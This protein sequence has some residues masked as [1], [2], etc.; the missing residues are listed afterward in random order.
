M[1][2]KTLVKA[3]NIIEAGL[4][5]LPDDAKAEWKASASDMFINEAIDAANTALEQPSTP[6]SIE[7][8]K[9]KEAMLTAYAVQEANR[10]ASTLWR[11]QLLTDE[12]EKDY[13]ALPTMDE[14]V[15]P[16][17]EFLE[18][19]QKRTDELT[20]K[21]NE[22]QQEKRELDIFMGIINGVPAEES[23]KRYEQFK[24]AQQAALAGAR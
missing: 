19:R 16:Y 18:A 5:L 6:G 1:E 3:N 11:L 4:A 24:N 13:R 7:M 17:N 22:L 12:L 10:M 2:L 8:F 15:K 21:G 20:E 9:E 23:E 14:V